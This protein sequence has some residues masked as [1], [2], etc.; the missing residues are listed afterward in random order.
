[1]NRQL[2]ESAGARRARPLAAAAIA[3]A[4]VLA[5]CTSAP[6]E[7]SATGGSSSSGAAS[8]LT[9]LTPPATG[10][11]DSITWNLGG[12]EPTSLDYS[13]TWDT[14]PG[15]MVLANL[16]DNL[17][18]Q[19]P[20][21]SYSPAVASAVTTPDDT[22]YVYDLREGVTFSDGTPVT[23]DDVVFSL[24][25]QLNP[26]VGSYWGVWFENVASVSATG[27]MQVTVKLTAP[28]VLFGQMMATPAG[29]VVQKA[30]VEAKGQDYG[31]AAGGV[32][33]TG[34]YELTEWATGAGITLTARDDYWDQTLQPKVKT[35]NFT[36]VR[37]PATVTNGLLTG[38][39]DG[40]WTAPISG[41]G[42]LSASTSGR[43]W[44]NTG[45]W[46]TMLTMASF[47]GAL[48]DP[49][50]RQAL[51]KSIDYEG[52]TTGLLQGTAVP[53][54][55]VVGP[56]YWGYAEDTYAAAYDALPQGQQDL[57]G[58]KA[59]VEAA[60]APSAP[61]VVAFDAGDSIAAST[62]ASIQDSAKQ[63]GLAVELKPLPAATLVTLF[64]DPAAR[65]GVDAIYSTSSGDIPE[66]LEAFAQFVSTSYLNYTGFV[67]PAYDE[68][69]AQARGEADP[70]AR[71]A[72][73]AEAQAAAAEIVQ[74]FLPLSHNKV[75]LYLN[76]RVTGAP[77]NSLSSLYYPWAATLGAP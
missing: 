3:G 35:I 45:T 17:M 42:Q 57:D 29:A 71:A 69:L 54:A 37:D 20:D 26:D 19:N 52:I 2:W 38:S 25:R 51:Q 23:A 59:L 50:I 53:A 62:V 68:P 41:L 34:P 77:V 31:T 65:E 22:T 46:A 75:L 18:R 67:N 56:A 12:G 70:E 60:G 47:S 63:V 14:G 72:L 11:L 27:P 55:S 21:S 16:C 30:Y 9:P 58:A 4:L 61:I 15:N 64:Y 32:M 39:I 1:M 8:G 33:C 49:R 5:G 76:N 74:T 13:Y 48:E 24:Q 10:P 44:S 36:F 6:D 40:T 43:V 73:V 66:P 28:D 7:P